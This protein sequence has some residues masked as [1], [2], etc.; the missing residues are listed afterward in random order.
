MYLVNTM[1]AVRYWSEVLRCAI[2]THFGDL[3]IKF[4]DLETLC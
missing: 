4:T 1:P 2:S 3:D